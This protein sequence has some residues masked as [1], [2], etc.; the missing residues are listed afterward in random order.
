M[1]VMRCWW[2]CDSVPGTPDFFLFLDLSLPVIFF[3]SSFPHV[4]L[5]C[6]QLQVG[7]D[8]VGKGLGGMGFDRSLFEMGLTGGFGWLGFSKGLGL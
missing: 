8:E 4:G 6:F 5:G 2:R 3:P 1:M 7:C